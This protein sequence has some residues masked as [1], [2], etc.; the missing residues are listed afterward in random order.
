MVNKTSKI[1]VS[2]LT[3]L[4]LVGVLCF[5]SSGKVAADDTTKEIDGNVFEKDEDG[6]YKCKLQYATYKYL[7]QN[8]I[9]TLCG[10]SLPSNEWV[11][12]NDEFWL[13][14]DI[15][16]TKGL[17]AGSD[18]NTTFRMYG[19]KITYNP[20]DSSEY[21]FKSTPEKGED[22]SYFALM[23]GN[24]TIYSANGAPLFLAGGDK[25]AS[26]VSLFL[27][28]VT[29]QGNSTSYDPTGHSAITLVDCGSYSSNYVTIQNFSAPKGGA[30][31]CYGYTTESYYGDTVYGGNASLCTT[32]IRN[33]Y[34]DEGGAIYSEKHIDCWNAVITDNVAQTRGGAICMGGTDADIEL[35]DCTITNNVCIAD[36]S[37]TT[38]GGGIY[39]GSTMVSKY[40]VDSGW[41][42]E[43]RVIG[44]TCGDNRPS[45]IY[46]PNN[47]T[48][49]IINF[50]S[51]FM[52]DADPKIGVSRYSYEAMD[53]VALDTY[54]GYAFNDE[55]INYIVSDDP[56]CD[57]FGYD[58]NS[59]GYY[60][61]LRMI[62]KM[63]DDQ[64]AF[65][66]GFSLMV[67]DYDLK[68]KMT[69]YIPNRE[70]D[71]KYDEDWWATLGPDQTEFYARGSEAIECAPG[72]V[73]SNGKTV[74]FIFPYDPTDMTV[75]LVFKASYQGDDIVEASGFSLE[76]YARAII[77][78]PLK[79]PSG[80]E[81]RVA[82]LVIYANACQKY[83]D[84]RMDDQIISA[85]DENLALLAAVDSVNVED[86]YQDYSSTIT[87]TIKDNRIKIYSMSGIFGSQPTI[88]I[89]IHV[90]DG[91]TPVFG[92]WDYDSNY[93]AV[94]IPY[95]AVDH[96]N[97]VYTI[98][99][100]KDYG[101]LYAYEAGFDD[102]I[103]YNQ[104]YC[105]YCY[106]DMTYYLLAK[107]QSDTASYNMKEL[108]RTMLIYRFV[109]YRG[110]FN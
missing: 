19:H 41:S 99:L 76:D 51:T 45:N 1:L 54:S 67:E 61:S 91:V 43:A 73:I 12:T 71:Y 81:N 49:D 5:I 55:T 82:A 18:Y 47:N 8:T 6:W 14:E 42:P 24:G 22:T 63:E 21:F 78:N 96:G 25:Y 94:F 53:I 20:A 84:F 13:G 110:T 74:S 36:K 56:D 46:F 60:E 83:F 52:D 32:T 70:E 89:Y 106:A 31:C 93:D 26:G 64:V 68:V 98:N 100:P 34:A 4:A 101:N 59:R 16:I 85:L 57:I 28:D 72:N 103:A 35:S 2:I 37:A 88:K 105:S 66:Q 87:A 33:C 9:D 23:G 29:L 40:A 92:N 30:F 95:E 50:S 7:D 38:G 62:E 77:R 11:D 86:K 58:K 75:P 10:G 107:L 27:N 104:D 48:R 102:T 3:M 108:A 15:T 44:N 97:G 79:Y 80:A 17:D 109:F 90:K 39:C 69:I 65:L